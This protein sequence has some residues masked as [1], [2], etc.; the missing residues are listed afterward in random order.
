MD[1]ASSAP[2]QTAV[3]PAERPMGL[4]VFMSFLT[5]FASLAAAALAFLF[6]SGEGMGLCLAAAAIAFGALAVA[7]HRP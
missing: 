2:V 3:Q 7:E 4:A 5:G 6:R 1:Q